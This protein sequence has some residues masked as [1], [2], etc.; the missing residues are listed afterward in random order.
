[1]WRLLAV[2]GVGVAAGCGADETTAPAAWEG[3]HLRF[4]SDGVEALCGGTLLYMDGAVAQLAEVLE[5]PIERRIDFY[6][7]HSPI[8]GTGCAAEASGCWSGSTVYSRLVPHD[9]EIVHA[10]MSPLGE[11]DR[12]LEEGVA[13]VHGDDGGLYEWFET[14]TVG[15]EELI[16]L[17]DGAVSASVYT[18]AAH[19]TRFLV[20]R[21]AMQSIHAF[22]GRVPREAS[23]EDLVAGFEATFG[24]SWEDF[25]AAYAG[26]P[27]CTRGALR[28]KVTECLAPNVGWGADGWRHT[29]DLAC[30]GAD[31]VGPTQGLMWRPV[32]L[33][34][35]ADRYRIEVMGSGDAFVAL[36]RCDAGCDDGFADAF[37]SGQAR[38]HE[39]PAG[40][41]YAKFWRWV[42]EPGELELRIT[43]ER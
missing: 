27:S 22:W 5:V 39:L 9:H 15:A 20:D 41:Y 16:G 31:V 17:D 2:A 11:A 7:H 43:P 35:P 37:Y 38:I 24:E 25:A 12:M 36:A 23:A 40:R 30:E 32:T 42:H 4:R 18:S 13:V 26:Y 29:M 14:P 21:Y 6:W 19:L 10:L 3:D 1:V 34:V 33:D 8:E 28:K